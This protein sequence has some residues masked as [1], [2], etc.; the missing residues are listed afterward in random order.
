M[1]APLSGSFCVR[2]NVGKPPLP[3]FPGQQFEVQ[4]SNCASSLPNSLVAKFYD[5][6]YFDH[7]QDDA[8]PFL[9]V[10]CAYSHEA[11]AYVTLK[12]LQGSVI[13]KY[14]GSYTL[15][16][17]AHSG[18]G[19]EQCRQVRLI[20]IEWVQDSMSMD[21]LDSKYFSQTERQTLMKA[22]VDTESAI[23][24]HGI[25]HRDVHPRNVMIASPQRP[26]RVSF[27]DFGKSSFKEPQCPQCSSGAPIPPLL[28]WHGKWHRHFSFCAWIDWDWQS[29][30]QCTYGDIGNAITECMKEDWEPPFSSAD[31][32]GVTWGPR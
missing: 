5:P 2:H 19:Q 29:W 30:L 21:K 24:N 8:D 9:C 15:D 23:Y 18:G 13:P 4:V 7:Q 10:D 11:A 31:H 12:E 3:Y 27:I 17:P 6:L 1:T 22:I 28:R 14:Y 26:S 32:P 16:L 20:L 25:H